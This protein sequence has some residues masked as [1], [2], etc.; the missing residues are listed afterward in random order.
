MS[1]T[2]ANN[3]AKQADISSEN[4]A[5][6]TRKQAY[7]AFKKELDE[8]KKHLIT[9]TTNELVNAAVDSLEKNLNDA[10]SRRH[11]EDVSATVK[12]II[13]TIPGVR[14]FDITRAEL[15]K[16]VLLLIDQIDNIIA[17]EAAKEDVENLRR[18]FIACAE[19]APDIAKIIGVGVIAES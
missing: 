13:G 1:N 6:P 19:H 18:V 7:E 3:T 5:L 12:D 9:A 15:Y 2:T 14:I 11:L 8:L 4:L 17:E 16:T 10:L